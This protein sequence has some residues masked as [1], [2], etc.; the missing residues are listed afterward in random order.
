[1]Y[2]P[3]LHQ[4]NNT[5]TSSR[6]FFNKILLQQLHYEKW[7]S[8]INNTLKLAKNQTKALDNIA[9]SLSFTCTVRCI[10]IYDGKDKAAFTDWLQRCKEASFHSGYHFRSALLQIYSQDVANIIRFLDEGLPHDCLA[11]NELA[12]IRQQPGQNLLVYINKFRDL[13]WWCSNK[14][15]CDG[16]YKLTISLFCSSLQDPIGKK[17]CKKLWDEKKSHKLVNLQKCLDEAIQACKQYRVTEH[18][19]DLWI[20]ES[21]VEINETS[22]Q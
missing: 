8:F 13:H 5:T 14:L 19:R 7:P 9:S 21:T 15:P 2:P 10:P 4:T 6:S 12:C 22:Y 18:R 17:L 1:M 11:I 3:P 20:L 16:D